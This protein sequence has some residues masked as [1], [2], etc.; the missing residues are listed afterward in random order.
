MKAYLFYGN[1]LVDVLEHP[2]DLLSLSFRIRAAYGQEIY[3]GSW[4]F[5]PNGSPHNPVWW[6]G[7]MVP[8][9]IQD[10]PQELRALALLVT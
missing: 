8:V 6:R 10:V 3:D 7:D 5:I 1:Q 4:L 9:L 2:A